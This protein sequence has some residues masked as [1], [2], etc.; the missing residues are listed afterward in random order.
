[1]KRIYPFILAVFA[2]TA[3]TAQPANSGMEHWIKLGL[4]NHPVLFTN[5]SSSNYNT[6][7]EDGSLNVTSIERP[8]EG[9]AIRMVNV[10]IDDNV[11]PGYF[12]VGNDPEIQNGSLYF[13]GGLY[14]TGDAEEITGIKLDVRYSFPDERPG[15]ILVQFKSQGEP[16]GNGNYDTGT[17]VFY[18]NGQQ[19]D[20]ETQEFLF[21]QAVDASIDQV[22]LGF[23]AADL[24]SDDVPYEAGSFLEIDNLEWV[25]T[26]TEIN[27]GN[28]DSWA[29]VNPVFIPENCV[30]DIHPDHRN[31]FESFDSH[32]GGRALAIMT[33]NT[34]QSGDIGWVRYGAIEGEDGITPTIVLEEE[35][36]LISFWYKYAADNDVAEAIVRFYKSTDLLSGPVFTKVFDLEP[37][38]EYTQVEYPFIDDLTMAGVEADLM[39]VEFR[40]SKEDN[41]QDG[42]ILT[43]DEF[44]VSGVSGLS[45]VGVLGPAIS[46]VKCY[47]NPTMGRAIFEFST[48]ASGMY[49]VYSSTGALIES[50]MYSTTDRLIHDMSTFQNGLYLFRFYHGNSYALVKVT[51]N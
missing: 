42:S 11:Q 20:W 15:M 7:F 12:L 1:M 48:P 45:P 27:G 43:V 6:F 21:D 2:C 37:T 22:V 41:P 25:G 47:P 33:D 46:I 31:Y 34:P 28:F 23:A 13:P 40:S 39:E 9:E 10:Q 8:N 51:K 4:F 26:D 49:R 17:W 3:L 16:V 24:V 35:S 44:E 36:D 18:L 32:A 5:T 38:M 14:F 29:L 19:T 30:V 50:R